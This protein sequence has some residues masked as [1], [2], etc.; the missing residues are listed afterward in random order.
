MNFHRA[1]RPQWICAADGQ[2]WPCEVARV[3]LTEA[4]PEPAVLVA[5]LEHLMATAALDLQTGD[6]RRLYRRFVAWA[7]NRNQICRACGKSGHDALPGLP[8]RL[9]PCDLAEADIGN[10][11]ARP[12]LPA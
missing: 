8:P 10:P 2:A 9:L 12:G 1:K 4:Y 5:H 3:A 11:V 6:P 7:L